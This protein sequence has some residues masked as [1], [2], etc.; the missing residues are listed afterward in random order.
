MRSIKRTPRKTTAGSIC[1]AG[2]ALVPLLAGCGNGSD[3]SS[4]NRILQIDGSST[5]FPVNEAVA[6]EFQIS[7]GGA[8][9][10]TV[11]VSGTG[12]GFK[13][14][15]RGELDVTGASRPI[16]AEE[17]RL[18][19]ENGIEY[20]ELPICFDAM[21][22]AV[23]PENDWVD[24]FTV[25]ELKK[26]WE[27][28]AQG[29]ITRWNQIREDWP[30][31]EMVL[32]GPGSDSGTFDYFTD[33][34]VGE[35]KSSRGDYTGSEDD[36]VLVRGIAGNKYALGYLPYAYYSANEGA[37]RAVPIEWEGHTD[38]PVAPTLENVVDGKYNPLARP[39]FIYV[40][41]DSAEQKPWVRD[42]VHFYLAEGPA[43]VQEVNYLPLS[44]RGY[45]MALERFDAMRTG[46]GFG[47]TPEVGL[48]IEEILNR[49]PTSEVTEASPTP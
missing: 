18:A 13:K 31:E 40:S 16:M 9:R 41:K 27:P 17:M 26:I 32:Y 38:G 12:G 24:S 47:G 22:V 10:V 6:E 21:T 48:P 33:A 25:A 14:F 39:L 8:I 2:L 35:A 30:D 46:T 34:I 7:T 1:A 36:N 19:N 15:A 29:E 4:R 43:L 20:I 28:A 3:P 11:G 23:S 44:E 5:V 37:L 45:E 49:P 42:F